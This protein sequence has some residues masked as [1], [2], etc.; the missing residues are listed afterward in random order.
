MKR[1]ALMLT[2]FI[3]NV[4]LL[5]S[6]SFKD[7]SLDKAIKQSNLQK[8]MKEISKDKNF[9]ADYKA[10][11][12]LFKSFFKSVPEK[13]TVQPRF[14]CMT[15]G[16]EK[17]F[18]YSLTIKG[19]NFTVYMSEPTIDEKGIHGYA[20]ILANIDEKGL[21]AP[22]LKNP[23]F[24]L[25]FKDFYIHSDGTLESGMSDKDG[26]NTFFLNY[27]NYIWLED[28]YLKKEEKDYLIVAERAS[29]NM[30]L[31]SGDNELNIGKTIFSMKGKVISCE[32]I[33]GEQTISSASL[34]C[35]ITFGSVAWNGKDFTGECRN[36]YYPALDLNFK[37]DE[38][39]FNIF[40]DKIE[41]TLKDKNTRFTICD[42]PFTADS[43]LM[44]SGQLTLKNAV[45]YWKNNSKKLGDVKI[46][47]GRDH[48]S[49]QYLF[50][51][52]T[53]KLFECN[54]R[55]KI[56]DDE[57]VVY[58]YTFDNEL[59]LRL[60]FK[61]KFPNQK[62]YAG[63]FKVNVDADGNVWSGRDSEHP[64]KMKIKFDQTEYIAG[65][66]YKIEN[67]KVFVEESELHF[68]KNCCLEEST[69]NKSSIINQDGSLYFY[70]IGIPSF[71]DL[72]NIFE[73]SATFT[74]DGLII[75]GKLAWTNFIDLPGFFNSNSYV[76]KLY[77]GFD[78]L[79]K[80]IVL[81]ENDG[82]HITAL[83]SGWNIVSNKYSIKVNQTK[84]KEGKLSAA[85]VLLCF[86]DCTLYSGRN[87]IPVKNLCYRLK[88]ESMGFVYD[89]VV[90]PDG[91]EL[92]LKSVFA[93]KAYN[94]KDTI[95]ISE[96]EIA[97]I[98][99]IIDDECNE[100]SRQNLFTVLAK[101]EYDE[102][103]NEVFEAKQN[104]SGKLIEYNHEYDSNGN[105]ILSKFKDDS[106][107]LYEIQYEYDGRGRLIKET[108]NRA[109]YYTRFEYENTADGYTEKCYIKKPGQNETLSSTAKYDK[110]GK[111]TSRINI[112]RTDTE[113]D[114]YEYYDGLL[115]R[116]LHTRNYRGTLQL[117]SYDDKDRLIKTAVEYVQVDKWDN[118]RSN[119]AGIPVFYKYNEH[120]DLCAEKGYSYINYT[121]YEYY[122]DGRMK[123]K[124]IY[125]YS[126]PL[127]EEM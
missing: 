63:K 66:P 71:F 8:E 87:Y 98:N 21:N 26:E 70:S 62:D 37:S 90:L 102:K 123:S 7:L 35:D 11:N 45:I 54:D 22:I 3:L 104:D 121:S 114:F 27:S 68:P 113:K 105:R 49:S 55:I 52:P 40:D 2:C 127:P 32:P 9:I 93:R 56:L 111:V 12:E 81:K 83:E 14:T 115:F 28:A 78:G 51:I 110:T 34:Y 15:N 60:L 4:G 95:R 116:T 74:K 10:K 38:Y 77:V 82:T 47:V 120:G 25:C 72:G 53:I 65:N 16:T 13:F 126:Y 112:S 59:G 57:D 19:N 36:I 64:S 73:D 39:K 50:E 80:E 89:D 18:I 108:N 101:Y 75:S 33:S 100:I 1:L 88:G 20:Q 124:T 30:D 86:D 17:K 61:T 76:E 122:P 43:L 117:C 91:V 23:F 84:D 48:S 5:F 44:K 99:K 125:T 92:D 58:A 109:E 67:G 41:A 106:G 103:G 97:E 119:G 85:Q 69:W 107:K 46:R 31:I 79:V 42:F 118:F 6:A 29:H 96:K 94:P 24:V